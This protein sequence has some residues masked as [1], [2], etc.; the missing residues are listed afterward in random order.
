MGDNGE[1][2]VGGISPNKDRDSGFSL[3]YVCIL[4]WKWIAIWCARK[5]LIRH[6]FY[7]EAN[8]RI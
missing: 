8:D 4:M 1:M 7:G 2:C 6:S 5:D 3:L